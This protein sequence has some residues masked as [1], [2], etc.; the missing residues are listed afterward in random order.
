MTD[1]GWEVTAMRLPMWAARVREG[2]R[3]HGEDHHRNR[4]EHRQH[5]EGRR[6]APAA[7]RSGVVLVTVVLAAGTLGGCGLFGDDD[8]GGSGTSVPVVELADD[9]SVKDAKATIVRPVNGL[10][11]TVDVLRLARRDKVLRL[12]FA[13][14]PRSKGSTSSLSSSF[15]GSGS[16]VDG[17]VLLDTVNLREY[18]PLTTSDDECVCSRDLGSFELDESTVVFADYPA[19]PDGVKELTIAFPGLGP[20]AGVPVS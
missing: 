16:E 3:Q 19:P 1:E 6:R 12:E 4:D 8:G 2:L 9:G 13:V 5:R 17:V 11:V 15:F 20:V 7:V 10:E 18:R 14:T